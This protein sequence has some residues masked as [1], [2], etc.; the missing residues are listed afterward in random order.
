MNIVIP[1]L[2]YIA[3]LFASH[4]PFCQD[5][6]RF[7][8]VNGPTP[9]VGKTKPDVFGLVGHRDGEDLRD[10]RHLSLSFREAGRSTA[11]GVVV[12][13]IAR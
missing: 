10:E 2:L 1:S 12:A 3:I 13:W 8:K 9:C 7:G 5:L 4:L 11:D 6:H